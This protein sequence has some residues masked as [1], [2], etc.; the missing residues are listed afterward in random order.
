[1]NMSLALIWAAVIG[2]AL[3]QIAVSDAHRERVQQ[4]QQLESQRE[5]L[6]DEQTRLVLE[7]SALTSYA[8]V[9]KQARTEL[10]MKEPDDIRILQ[11]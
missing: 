3:A 10:N 7:L 5:A 4:W 11:P 1:M 9:D 6:A 2:S 8:R